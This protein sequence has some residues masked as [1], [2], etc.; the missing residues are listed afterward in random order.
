M[1]FRSVRTSVEIGPD[2]L[3]VEVV[4]ARGGGTTAV[5]GS[6]YG[7]IGMRE[8]VTLAGGTLQVGRTTED[9]YRV[10]AEFPVLEPA[11]AS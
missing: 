11:A 4:N 10:R 5:E 3:A 6:G 7:L 2:G 8:R 1:L 9:G